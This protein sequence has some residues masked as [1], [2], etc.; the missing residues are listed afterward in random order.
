MAS[1]DDFSAEEWEAISDGPVYAASRSSSA[2]VRSSR[3]SSV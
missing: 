3:H 1:R 2:P